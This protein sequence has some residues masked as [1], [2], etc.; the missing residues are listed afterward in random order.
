MKR[1]FDAIMRS[2]YKPDDPDAFGSCPPVCPSWIWD[3]RYTEQYNAVICWILGIPFRCHGMLI[4]PSRGLWLAGNLGTGKSTLMRAVKAFCRVY[5]DP[6]S[7]NLPSHMLWRHAKEIVSD[8]EES[9]PS[10]IKDLADVANPLII[11]DLG[12]ENMS[13]MRYGNVRNVI[14]EILS[15][16]YDRGFSTMVTTNFTMDDVRQAY[17]DRI[18]DRI[19][20][21]FSIIYF[22]GP[23]FRENFNPRL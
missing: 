21:S 23:S 12:T 19:R 3:E 4:S 18:Y 11:D 17:R 1:L 10:A 7:P 20:E 15:R 5:S 22:L 13:A 16:R 2:G 6:R 8:Y 14:E 9:G